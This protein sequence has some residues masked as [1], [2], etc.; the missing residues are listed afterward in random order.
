MSAASSPAA[1]PA[2]GRKV[3]RGTKR[4]ASLSGSWLRVLIV[5][6]G[7]A[8]GLFFASIQIVR[9]VSPIPAISKIAK[10]TTKKQ[11]DCK[12]HACMDDSQKGQTT[13]VT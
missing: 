10:Q 1:N 8:N 7:G 4:S 13:N 6:H 12:L 5:F 9:W 2:L 11:A 3:A